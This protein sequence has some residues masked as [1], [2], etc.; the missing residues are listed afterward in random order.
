LSI[1]LVTRDGSSADLGVLKSWITQVEQS[2]ATELLI[3]NAGRPVPFELSNSRVTEVLGLTDGND[4]TAEGLRRA[5]GSHIRYASDDDPVLS[6]AVHDLESQVLS[7]DGTSPVSSVGDFILHSRYGVSVC[8]QEYQLYPQGL[9]TY[10]R[11]ISSQGAIPAFYSVYPRQLVAHWSAYLAEYPVPFSYMD[12]LLTMLAFAY[13]RVSHPG[14]GVM[15][16]HY[17]LTN[18][19][20]RVTSERRNL[21]IMA[22]RGVPP[23]MLPLINLFWIL[24]ALRLLQRPGLQPLQSESAFKSLIAKDQLKRFLDNLEFRIKLI[25]RQADRAY[26]AA[27]SKL[28]PIVDATNVDIDKLR[29]GLAEVIGDV[30]GSVPH[31][32]S[33]YFSELEITGAC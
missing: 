8:E 26:I 23:T 33:H 6:N 15:M 17:D 3:L 24:D 2:R 9:E 11:F 5:R 25:S 18:W 31:S 22:S 30:E 27:V 7:W 10:R 16:S 21:K 28:S 19:C 32:L 14:R 1:F 29:S 4:R 12:W 13:T 20:D